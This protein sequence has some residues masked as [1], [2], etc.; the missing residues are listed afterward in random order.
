MNDT[1]GWCQN[2]SVTEPQREDKGGSLRHERKALVPLREGIP[3]LPHSPS[4]FCFAKSTSLPEG[5][6][7]AA[8]CG[9]NLFLA[10]GYGIRPY[11]VAALLFRLLSRFSLCKKEAQR[12]K[13]T[14][15]KRRW[16]S[17]ARCDARP[18]FRRRRTKNF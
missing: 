3:K 7:L 6:S 17:F 12:E 2:A 1:T 13:L 8:L 5:G 9:A 10:G 18:A 16:G 11:E 4:V 15:E 14:K